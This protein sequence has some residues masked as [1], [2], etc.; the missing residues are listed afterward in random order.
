MTAQLRW[1]NPMTGGWYHVP[2][3]SSSCPYRWDETH[4]DGI[5]IVERA[6]RAIGRGRGSGFSLL[7]DGSGNLSNPPYPCAQLYVYTECPL[8]QNPKK[9]VLPRVMTRDEFGLFV[10][11]TLIDDTNL[12]L[13]ETE[14]F[15][16]LRLRSNQVSEHEHEITKALPRRFPYPIGGPIPGHLDKG[17]I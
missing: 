15:V 2:V 1:Q 13:L 5:S 14:L 7:V 8:C 10:G 16:D 12:S 3:P 6:I 4:P 11:D 9:S 17:D